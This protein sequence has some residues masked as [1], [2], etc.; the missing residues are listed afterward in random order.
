[1]RK[2]KILIVILG[3]LLLLIGG[4]LLTVSIVKA[5]SPKD[6]LK[7]RTVEI[8][9]SFVGITVDVT[10]ANVEIK[11]ATDG[12][13]KVEFKETEKVQY[14]A[15]VSFGKLMITENDTRAWYEKYFFRFSYFN[16][17]ATIYV[18]SDNIGEIDLKS[19]TGSIVI[20]D[21][22]NYNTVKMSSTTGRVE[23]DNARVIGD[24]TLSSTT[25]SVT[26][27]DSTSK[28]IK[29]NTSTGGIR[30]N[31][32]I[33]EN[34]MKL[35]TATG[36]VSFDSCDAKDINVK[37]STGGVHGV[38]LTSK[39]FSCTSSTGGIHVPESDSNAEG[40]CVVSTSTGGINITI[41]A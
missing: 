34:S 9:D 37:T 27:K 20:S 15:K 17:V 7:S 30:L 8:T 10:E 38:L 36:G 4:G 14:D 19:Q 13:C 6:E 5:D 35:E 24:I 28:N 2:V 39:K 29:V 22:F 12:V 33:A 21:A 18:P 16:M 1:M 26:V 31:N 41:K 40:T 3:V 25:G 23:L 11:K 32:Y